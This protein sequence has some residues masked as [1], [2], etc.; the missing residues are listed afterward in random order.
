[1]TPE[2]AK[3]IEVA[4]NVCWKRL[5]RPMIP[6]EIEPWWMEQMHAAALAYA[7]PIVAEE[8]AVLVEETELSCS[9]FEDGSFGESHLKYLS[10][11][12]REHG[13]EK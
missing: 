8:C 3:L 1:M 12:I 5:P 13:K 11:Y 9:E 2:D 10:G 6:G 4:Q 7:R